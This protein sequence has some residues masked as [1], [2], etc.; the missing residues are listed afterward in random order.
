R[1][2]QGKKPDA[3]VGRIQS[4][5]RGRFVLR[6]GTIRFDPFGY[7]VPVAEVDIR[8]V[9]GLRSQQLDFAGTLMMDA[10]VSKAAGGGIK[11]FFLKSFDALL[12]NK[13]KWRVLKAFLRNPCD[14]LFRKKGKGAVLPIT[15]KGPR[16]SPKFGLNWGKVFK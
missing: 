16:E 1:R 10:A 13:G 11:G 12:R 9:Y 6:S 3:P 14:P 15:I 7:D 4:D 2:A 5:M 8:G